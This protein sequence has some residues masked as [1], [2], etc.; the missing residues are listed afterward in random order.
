MSYYDYRVNKLIIDTWYR[1]SF[2]Y[3]QNDH[4]NNV[5]WVINSLGLTSSSDCQLYFFPNPMFDKDK[6]VRT[7]EFNPTG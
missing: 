4:E 1:F 7:A 5:R 3:Y 6:E 2:F